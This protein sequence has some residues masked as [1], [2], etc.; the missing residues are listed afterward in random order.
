MLLAVAVLAV[1]QRGEETEVM[2]SGTGLFTGVSLSSEDCMMSLSILSPAAGKK[3]NKH[4]HD[5]DWCNI[6]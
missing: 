6:I 3:K 4:N 2:L 5:L 1:I